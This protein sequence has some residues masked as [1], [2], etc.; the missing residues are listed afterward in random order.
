M[1]LRLIE[2]VEHLSQELNNAKTLISDLSNKM[3]IHRN[4]NISKDNQ[5]KVY[6]FI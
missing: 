3:M 1:N 4:A 2:R 5:I 6:I